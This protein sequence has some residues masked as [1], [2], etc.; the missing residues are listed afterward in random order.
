MRKETL[1]CIGRRLRKARVLIGWSREDVR[2]VLGL[3]TA[4]HISDWERG[5]RLPNVI[6]L[7]KLSILYKTLPDELVYELRQEIV[8]DMEAR[9]KKVGK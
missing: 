3:T 1:H 9:L 2:K 6:S 5:K 7:L 8:R 4:N